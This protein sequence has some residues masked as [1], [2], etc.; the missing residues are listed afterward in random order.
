MARSHEQAGMVAVDDD[1]GEMPLE[2]GERQTDGLDEVAVV[3][4][5]DEVGDRLRVGLRGEAVPLGSEA[6]LQLAV[7]LDDAVEHD[8]DLG[9]VASRQRVGVLLRDTAVRRPARVP[10]A[11]GRR[12]AVRPG[13]LLQVVEDA[14]G[15]HVVEA[16]GL[17]QREPG[18]VV[19][20]V[21]QPLEPLQE[22]GL[23]FTRADVSD[24]SA[25]VLSVNSKSPG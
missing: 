17:E 5:L 21:L 4:T 12:R 8:R 24:D 19:A 23:A 20:A 15:T 22:K 2:L 3:V 18:G 1:E 7:V 14:D 11:G 10:D 16:A 25:H 6:L 13:P 9:G